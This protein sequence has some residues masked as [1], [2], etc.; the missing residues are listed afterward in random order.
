MDSQLLPGP[1]RR[2][3]PRH[4]APRYGTEFAARD[5]FDRRGTQRGRESRRWRAFA[6]LDRRRSRVS[7]K[8]QHKERPSFVQ[9]RNEKGHFLGG[10]AAATTAG[11]YRNSRDFAG[12]AK[13]IAYDLGV[14]RLCEQN[15]KTTERKGRKSPGIARN[16]A[17]AFADGAT[18]EAC[19]GFAERG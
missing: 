1:H 12:H 5:Y 16:R 10:S 13:E 2:G 6:R 8:S 3:V 18:P 15:R 14:E 11:T 17:R 9:H 7:R 19:A 4:V